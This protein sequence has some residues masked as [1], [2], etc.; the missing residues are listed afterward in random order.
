MLC[1]L[2]CRYVRDLAPRQLIAI[3]LQIVL[4]DTSR[5]VVHCAGASHG[6]GAK[7]PPKK[8]VPHL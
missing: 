8:I 1:V 6:L 4:T 3:R 2:R 5:H 7:P